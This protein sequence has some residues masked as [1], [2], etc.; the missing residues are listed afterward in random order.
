MS[1]DWSAKVEPVP[2]AK[3]DNPQSLNLY[4]YAGNNPESVFDPDGHQQKNKAAGTVT[5][6]DGSCPTD[7]PCNSKKVNV[8]TGHKTQPPA[9]R[10]PSP[11]HWQYSQ[12]TGS[13]DLKVGVV[14]IAHAG[15]GYAG[16]GKGLN[17][18]SSQSVSEDADKANAGPL[19]R[20]HYTVGP[21][22]NH[23]GPVSMHLT[24]APGSNMHGRTSFYIHGDNASKPPL[25]S[26]EGCIVLSRPSRE[27][28]AT[29]GVTQLVVVH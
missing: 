17:N 7:A 3:L 5:V 10:P 2:Y 13:M 29:S 1:P 8:Q 22:T 23:I 14:T 18:P 28:I 24:P 15:N 27:E 6:Q 12:S 20:A 16:H 19:V 25:S 9:L 4:A 21:P 11:P 26:S